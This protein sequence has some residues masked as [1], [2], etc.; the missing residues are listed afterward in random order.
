MLGVTIRPTL[1]MLS[2]LL[3]AVRAPAVFFDERP[4]G[5]DRNLKGQPASFAVVSHDESSV[6]LALIQ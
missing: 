5:I 6:C 2:P 3:C 1:A 4:Y